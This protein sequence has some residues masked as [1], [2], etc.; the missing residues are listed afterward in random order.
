M[1]LSALSLSLA[2]AAVPPIMPADAGPV[3]PRR[4]AVTITDFVAASGGTF[5]SNRLDYDILL[6]AVVAADL[7]G[8]LANPEADLTLFAP[9]DAAFIRL[10]RDLGYAGFAED[11]A[12]NFLV[13]A[14]T[15]LGGGDPIPVLTQV[16]LYHVAPESL[17]VGEVIAAGFGGGT[18]TT[19]QG[20]AITPQGTRLIDN[21]PDLADA[22]LFAPLQVRLDNGVVHTITSVLIPIDLP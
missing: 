11:G 7:G 2:V 21:E 17:G 19:L 20:G 9:N 1:M 16:L 13:A 10:A 3:A 14:L 5:D 15:D 12:W 6:N 8:A 4:D 22:R 18:I